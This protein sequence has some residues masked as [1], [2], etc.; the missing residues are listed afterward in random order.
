LDKQRQRHSEIK[1]MM[2]RQDCNG[3]AVD[4]YHQSAAICLQEHY[5]QASTPVVTIDL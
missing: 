5:I 4:K 3:E 2:T 1:F